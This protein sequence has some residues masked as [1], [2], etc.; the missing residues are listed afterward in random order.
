MQMDMGGSGWMWMTD[1]VLFATFN[2]QGGE[3]GVREFKS[4]N[5]F[6]VSA[7]RDVGP[8]Q[9]TLKG[10]FT[11]E[12]VTTTRR[13]YAE[14]FQMGEAYHHLENIDRQHPHDLFAQLAAVWQRPVGAY[15]L[16]FAGAP[17]GEATL[18]PVAF[19]HRPSASENPT[20]PLSHHTLDSTHTVQGLVGAAVDRGPLTVEGS[21]FRG[22]EPDEDRVDIDFGALDSW[23]TRVWYRPSRAWIAQVSYGYLHQPEELEPGDIRRVTGSVSWQR[24][25]EAHLI[26]ISAMVGHNRKIYNTNLTAFLSEATI[27][28]DRWFFY[29]RVEE[30]QIE[31]EHLFFPTVAHVPHPRELIDR[32]SAYTGGVGFSLG[33]LSKFEF[34]VAGDVTGYAVPDRLVPVYD[35][36]PVSSHVFLRIRPRAGAMGRMWNMTLIPH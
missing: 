17:V 2:S 30:L 9:L 3:R 11:I 16:S 5:W 25:N 27:R 26:A 34:A 6:M 20:A 13:G 36:H 7:A 24:G 28:R 4:Q 15:R 22:R 12:P 31:T 35:A 8:G 10:M 1:G 33:T 29:G 32:L 19:M 21:W 23:A 14:L 18:G